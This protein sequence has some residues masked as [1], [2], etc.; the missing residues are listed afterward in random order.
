MGLGRYGA[1]VAKTPIRW[2]PPNLGGRTVGDHSLCRFAEKF[3]IIQ[4]WEN[5]SSPRIMSG[6]EIPVPIPERNA[7][8]V[9]DLP[10]GEFRTYWQNRCT[11]G[12]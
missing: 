5:P 4:M 1:R 2:F 8:P 6:F 10:A 3:Q 7:M 12:Q 9:P 11:H